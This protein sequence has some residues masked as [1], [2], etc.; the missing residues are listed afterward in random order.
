M[1]GIPTASTDELGGPGQV[2]RGPQPFG[3][4]PGKAP[5][6]S[7]A[8]LWRDGMGTHDGGGLATTTIHV[9]K[10]LKTLE[11]DGVSCQVLCGQDENPCKQL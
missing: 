6:G 10:D 9:K 5:G 4:T 11:G 2:Y 8:F 7:P 3:T 1:P